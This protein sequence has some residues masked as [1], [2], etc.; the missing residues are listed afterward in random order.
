MRICN[1]S[2]GCGWYKTRTWTLIPTI[3]FRLMGDEL[4]TKC[5]W[6]IVVTWLKAFAEFG[7]IKLKEQ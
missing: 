3:E 2:C 4:F 7:Y 1:F 6:N 5:S